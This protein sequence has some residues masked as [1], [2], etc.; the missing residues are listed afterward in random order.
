MDE[1]CAQETEHGGEKYLHDEAL[2]LATYGIP[3]QLVESYQQK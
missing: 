3:G 2:K 1:S